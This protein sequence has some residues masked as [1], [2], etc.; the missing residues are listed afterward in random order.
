MT[1]I[2]HLKRPRYFGRALLLAALAASPLAAKTIPTVLPAPDPADKG[3][4][5]KPVKVYILSGQSNMLG[6]GRV[7]GAEPFYS[8]V[9]LS[10]DPTLTECKL[11]TD[12]AALLRFGVFQSAATDAEPG[13]V[14]GASTKVALGTTDA[15]I[16][17]ADG[18]PVVVKAFIEVPYNG[19][20]RIHPA[21]EA[22][23]KVNDAKPGET[24]GEVK[25]EKG[26]RYPIEITY[27]KG[28]GSAALWLEKTRLEGMGD[29]RFVVEK[30][31]RFPYMLDDQGQWTAR[32]DVMLNDAY[33]GKGKSDPLSAPACGP[34]FGPELGFGYVMGEFHD[35][36]V[37]VMKAD[38]GNRS[39]GWDILPPGSERYVFEGKEQPGYKEMFD[40]DGKVIPWDGK[41]WYA[42]KQ[43]DDYTAAV[44][45]VLDNFGE[46]YP[47]YAD[48][49]YEVAGFVWWQGHK[50]GPNPAHN[51]RDEQN[52][53]NLIK[54]WRKEFNAPKAKWAIAT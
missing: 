4:R 53:V 50:D 39:L 32:Q 10:A 52:L 19:T 34:T 44:R 43:Y 5:D 13:G 31:E 46:K 29:L 37:I 45:A 11:P 20:Y 42:G 40:A 14:A 18:D 28:G 26:R 6:F 3:T 33:M 47:E 25:L 30:L 35:E 2:T 15:T 21:G 48:Q 17:E 27:A 23:V 7:E 22:A 9:F 24:D 38:I 12:N 8:Q 54:A 16:P 51:A 36:P 41:G 1:A 49:G